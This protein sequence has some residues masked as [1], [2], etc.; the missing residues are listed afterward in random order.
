MNN[1]TEQDVLPTASE[2]ITKNRR[3]LLFLVAYLV[4][5]ILTTGILLNGS[6]ASFLYMLQ[7]FAVVVFLLPYG[8]VIAI[9]WLLNILGI[10]FHLIEPGPTVTPANA[11]GSILLVLAYLACLLLPL[12][13]SITKRQRTFR[14]LFFTFVGLLIVNIAGC[15]RMV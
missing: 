15:S 10:N 6:D 7:T 3:P 14:I 1:H 12:A 5:A 13:G 2:T 11:M 8:L 9:D 4:A